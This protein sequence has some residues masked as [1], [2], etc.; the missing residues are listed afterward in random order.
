MDSDLESLVNIPSQEKE[1]NPKQEKRVTIQLPPPPLRPLPSAHLRPSPKAVD[2]SRR[3]KTL[4]T[5]PRARQTLADKMLEVQTL[6]WEIRKLQLLRRDEH[7]YADRIEELNQRLMVVIETG[8]ES[9][10]SSSRY[11]SHYSYDYK[12]SSHD[13]SRRTSYASSI[14]STIVQLQPQPQPQTAS[15]NTVLSPGS[16]RTARPVS[17]VPR[18]L[19][20]YERYSEAG[21]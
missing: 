9:S 7:E 8:D 6:M 21:H 1:Q 11:Y 20:I 13:A 17:R 4:S 15:A 12:H 16:S 14:Q 19:P 18:L 5:G 3:R 10:S 2:L